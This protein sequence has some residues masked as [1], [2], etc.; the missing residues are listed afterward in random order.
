MG[1]IRVEPMEKKAVF[2]GY[3]GAQLT[4]SVDELPAGFKL[5]CIRLTAIRADGEKIFVFIST[6]TAKEISNVLQ[7]A[8]MRLAA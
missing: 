7:F 8:A 6:A 3:Q 2:K 4:V 1:V 5:D